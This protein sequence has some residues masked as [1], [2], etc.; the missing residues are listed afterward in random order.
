MCVGARLTA[1]KGGAT[2][3]LKQAGTCLDDTGLAMQ[4]ADPVLLLANVAC[5]V[6]PAVLLMVR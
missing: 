3:P 4:L 6:L 5:W 1:G 2:Q